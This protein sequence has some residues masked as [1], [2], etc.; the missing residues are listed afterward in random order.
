[1]KK[2]ITLL[3]IT[4]SLSYAE[5]S[6]VTYFEYEDNL[7]LTRNYFT[8]KNDIS[9][10]LSFTFQTDVGKSTYTNWGIWC[11]HAI[12]GDEIDAKDMS[13]CEGSGGVWLDPFLWYGDDAD[14][15]LEVYLK[16][17]QL[18]WKINNDTKI[19]IW[20]IRIINADRFIPIK[21]SKTKKLN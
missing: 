8:Y 9:D 18:D 4:V 20:A 3:F 5:I 12:D 11:T 6:G 1:M 15:G 13:D 7:S 17:A 21:A 14:A 19:V 10:E 16:K 2:I